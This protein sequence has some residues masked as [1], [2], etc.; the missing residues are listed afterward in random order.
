MRKLLAH[1]PVEIAQVGTR[2]NAIV[3]SHF[4]IEVDSGA[5]RH[6][7]RKRCRF[8]VRRFDATVGNVTQRYDPGRNRGGEGLPEK[9]AQRLVLE[10]LNVPGRPVVDQQQPEYVSLGIGY[11]Y[12]LA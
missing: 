5:G 10:G 6:Q 11:R 8:L 2:D 9:G 12:R 7:I 4:E 1:G 3:D